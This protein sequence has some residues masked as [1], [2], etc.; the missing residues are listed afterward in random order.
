[1]GSSVSNAHCLLGQQARFTPLLTKQHGVRLIRHLKIN[2]VDN[3]SVF[4]VAVGNKV[5][6]AK[7]RVYEDATGLAT[8]SETDPVS[9]SYANRGRDRHP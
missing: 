6:T 4:G 9:R 7:L 8:L 1:M 2:N 3:V 5:G